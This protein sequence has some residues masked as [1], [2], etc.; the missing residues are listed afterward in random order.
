MSKEVL[1]VEG[2]P[3]LYDESVEGSPLLQNGEW[4]LNSRQLQRPLGAPYRMTLSSG[5]HSATG[6]PD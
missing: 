1:V 2:S 4:A 6:G 3:L 5:G